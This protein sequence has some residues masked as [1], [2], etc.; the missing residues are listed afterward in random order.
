MTRQYVALIRKDEESGYWID[1]PD[2]S[3]C[4]SWGKTVEEAVVSLREAIETYLELMETKVK[5]TMPVPRSR[6]EIIE[7]EED[8]F[9]DDFMIDVDLLVH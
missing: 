4:V 7:T 8:E 2:M 1:I 6:A 3:G 5:A 9:Y